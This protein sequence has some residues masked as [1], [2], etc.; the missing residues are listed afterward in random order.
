MMGTECLD[1][2]PGDCLLLDTYA[3]LWKASAED[4]ALADDVERV[5]ICLKSYERPHPLRPTNT[6]LTSRCTHVW[7]DGN[8]YWT[9]RV[10]IKAVIS[11][12][13]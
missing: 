8:V 7:F 4:D 1:P 5:V 10:N 9:Y 3:G 12:T 6:E 13:S 11:P 2:R